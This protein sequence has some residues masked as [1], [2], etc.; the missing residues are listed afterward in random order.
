MFVVGNPFVY[1]YV[2]PKQYG[3]FDDPFSS[4]RYCVR[5]RPSLFR[6]SSFRQPTTFHQPFY[7]P[8]KQASSDEDEC[9]PLLFGLFGLSTPTAKRDQFAECQPKRNKNPA[10]F[11]P[12]TNKRQVKSAKP[13]VSSPLRR[14]LDSQR[15]DTDTHIVYKFNYKCDDPSGI[16]V[17]ITKDGYINLESSDGYV[18]KNRVPDNV[19]VEKAVCTCVNKCLSL[20]LPRKL[21]T[22][23]RV[24]NQMD[25]QVKHEQK[26]IKGK[27]V[28]GTVTKVESTTEDFDPDAPIV[29]DIIEND[30][31]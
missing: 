31:N 2:R 15:L 1:D 18:W 17:S 30:D 16:N 27:Q 9:D 28:E 24:D 7:Q 20:K 3:L 12:A 13:K 6:S 5:E 10:L 29:E 4:G 8:S 25:V 22:E 21:A 14:E 26:S 23:N 11:K 19:D